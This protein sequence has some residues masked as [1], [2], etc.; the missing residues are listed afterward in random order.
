MLT[1]GRLTAAIDRRLLQ[2]VQS[3]ARQQAPILALVPPRWL[4]P[5]LAPTVRRLRTKLLTALLVVS[6]LLIGAVL[7]R[8]LL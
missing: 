1:P 4:A 2:L 6:A 8:A 5:L 3:R 7:W